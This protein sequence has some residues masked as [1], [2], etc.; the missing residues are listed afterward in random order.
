MFN[1]R[2]SFG[3]PV[4]GRTMWNPFS[5][6]PLQMSSCELLC[7]G[8]AH[9]ATWGMVTAS[10]NGG[11]SACARNVLGN[12]AC[13]SYGVARSPC[14]LKCS[15]GR[16][17]TIQFIAGTSPWSPVSSRF[18][19]LT[20]CGHHCFSDGRAERHS[21]MGSVPCRFCVCGPDIL[22]HALLECSAHT[23]SRHRW[24]SQ[25]SWHEQ[26]TPCVCEAFSA[27]VPQSTQQDRLMCSV[28]QFP[29]PQRHVQCHAL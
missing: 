25:A 3:L 20:R 2:D 21:N 28:L 7:V 14:M 8:V 12:A 13:Y 15:R 17:Y 16:S 26:R 10:E 22:S 11:L 23:A 24:R 4:F 6:M 9:P 5:S 19:G 27:L 1:V 18:W 29:K